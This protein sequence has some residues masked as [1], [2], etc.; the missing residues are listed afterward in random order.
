MKQ[1]RISISLLLRTAHA[2]HWILVSLLAV[3]DQRVTII[4][5][6]NK[7][8]QDVKAL[9]LQLIFSVKLSHSIQFNSSLIE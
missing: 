1:P 3:A 4:E 8:G 9:L 6:Q 7:Q 5:R 2:I